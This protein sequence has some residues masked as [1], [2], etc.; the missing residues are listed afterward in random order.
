MLAFLECVPSGL[1]L[2]IY[3]VSVRYGDAFFWMGGKK[4]GT[5]P[6]HWITGPYSTYERWPL[7][8]SD[9]VAGN[10][11]LALD[12]DYDFMWQAF[13][14]DRTAYFICEET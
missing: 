6:A 4:S 5:S 2:I 11:C 7:G 3:N 9:N 1:I 10:Q 13:H 12:A 8:V 14:C